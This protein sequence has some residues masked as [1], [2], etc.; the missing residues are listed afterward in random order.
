M[1]KLQLEYF[2]NQ[3]PEEQKNKELSDQL[4]QIGFELIGIQGKGAFGIVF[5]IK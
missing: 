4:Q 5:K 3:N 2:L 1:A